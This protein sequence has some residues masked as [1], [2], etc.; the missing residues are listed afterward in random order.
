MDPSSGHSAK[1]V[2]PVSKL[3]YDRYDAY[4]AGSKPNPAPLG[5]A[6]AGECVDS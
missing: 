1:A 6:G 4:G 5:C 3:G 2:A